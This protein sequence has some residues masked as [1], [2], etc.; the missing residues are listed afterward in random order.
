MK[1]SNLV[2][3]CSL[4]ITCHPFTSCTSRELPIEVMLWNTIPRVAGARHNS[5]RAAKIII[6]HSTWQNTGFSPVVFSVTRMLLD[7]LPGAVPISLLLLSR[8]HLR[9]LLHGQ[10]IVVTLSL[11]LLLLLVVVGV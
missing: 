8:L 3:T 5:R 6:T 4:V 2:L 1:D 9:L 10:S 7:S 11:V